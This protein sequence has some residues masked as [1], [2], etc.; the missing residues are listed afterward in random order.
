MIT[1]IIPTFN[2]LSHSYLLPNLEN[3]SKQNNVEIICVDGGSTDG[4]LL[5]LDSKPVKVIRLN[6]NSRSVR[7]NAGILESSGE[8]ILLHH[9]RSKIDLRALD[10]LQNLMPM[11]GGLKHQFDL[12]KIPLLLRFTSWYSNEVRGKLKSIVY[13]DH[14]IFAKRSLLIDVG[15]IPEVDIFED[16]ELS[17]KLRKICNAKIIP[18]KSVTSAVRFKKNG[19]WFQAILNQ[20]LKIGYLCNVSNKKMNKIYEKGLQLNSNYKKRAT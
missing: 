17:I 5:L 15:K 20:I 12:K 18:F 2:E 19:I 6:T 9:P 4:T 13:L 3:L 16:T 14:C 1:I 7:L 11:W 10:Y 8:M